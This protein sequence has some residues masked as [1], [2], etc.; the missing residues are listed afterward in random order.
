MAPPSGEPTDHPE[1]EEQPFD[2]DAGPVP[3]EEIEA[4]GF[5]QADEEPDLGIVPQDQDTPDGVPAAVVARPIQQP[6]R[7][8]DPCAVFAGGECPIGLPAAVV[9]GQAQRELL[10]AANVR[11]GE[12][13]T[14][15]NGS[16]GCQADFVE[17]EF[18][19][20]IAATIPSAIEFRYSESLPAGG[21]TQV[22]RA[23][24]G[25]GDAEYDRWIENQ[26]NGAF[27]ETNTWTWF[28]TCIALDLEPDVFYEF[29]PITATSIDGQV[30]TYP[31]TLSISTVAPGETIG[32]PPPTFDYGTSGD[33]TVHVWKRDL[34]DGYRAFVWPIDLSGPEP[35]TCSGVEADLFADGG[36]IGTSHPDFRVA[37][38][39]HDAVPATPHS[40]YDSDY[41]F[42]QQFD[43]A[44]REGRTYTVCMWD[45]KLGK[46]SF[47]EW[48]IL[49]REQYDV[50][51]PNSHPIV[52]NLVRVGV[53]GDASPHDVHVYAENH[54]YCDSRGP[55]LNAT[56]EGVGEGTRIAHEVFCE[57]WGLPL[58]P[59]A[60][61]RIS[62]DREIADTLAIPLD[63]LTNCGIGTADP[64]CAIRTSEYVAHTVEI[65]GS[66]N[67]ECALVDMRFRVDYLPSNGRGGDT[68][69]VGPAGTFDGMEPT[70][71]VG[72]DVDTIS[73][74]LDPVPDR[75]DQM[76]ATFLLKSPSDYTI[77]AIATV[78]DS[79]GDESCNST[80]SGSG[81]G[82]V[83]VTFEGM[84]AN[85]QY[86][87][88]SIVL[89]DAEGNTTER[90][91]RGTVPQ[92]WTN[93]YASFLW[94]DVSMAFLDEGKA[95][96]RCEEADDQGGFSR[97]ADED[98]WNSL[99]V[100]TTSP[101][102][103]GGHQAYALEFPSCVS[104][105]GAASA[106]F[107]APPIAGN[108]PPS[109]AVVVGEVV[110]I[111][112]RFVVYVLPDCGSGGSSPASFE[113]LE[114]HEQ[115]PLDLLDTVVYY[116]FPATDGIEWTV[117]VRRTDAGIANRR[118]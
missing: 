83:E 65:P 51:T 59:F 57:S 113:V 30:V 50:V 46:T 40:I 80:S 33:L 28:R 54:D 11:R 20:W 81:E 105:I 101:V 71:V 4:A 6:V 43:M 2:F 22:S 45:V 64:G 96:A 41:G 87:L 47:D 102:D 112:F 92:V 89:T 70:V 25:P 27:D 38:V 74:T 60:F 77:T 75:V 118:R 99:G 116:T 90:D 61:T 9:I 17:G 68:W 10:L 117:R 73:V 94:T 93:G 67:P 78:Q 16:E 1:A 34:E 111:D 104:P 35:A 26:S 86:A 114:V 84:C 79:D 24:P 48:E 23:L 97:G 5:D 53:R 109:S 15:L 7:F 106:P 108:P 72:P 21:T 44:L 18:N 62:V 3:I 69:R 37:A 88:R 12:P 31:R 85:S 49:E 63:P 56:V 103:L 82:R 76:K 8:A 36:R 100:A 110:D 66:C 13:G 91:L 39:R 32:K 95:A 42:T 107:S 98:C 52:M 115:V 55:V 58:E 29:Y 19:I 14:T